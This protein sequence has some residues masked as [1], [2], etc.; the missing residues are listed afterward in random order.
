M[1]GWFFSVRAE[2][3]E[4]PIERQSWGPLAHS[5]CK[6][7]VDVHTHLPTHYGPVPSDEVVV[8]SAMRPG[9]HV[10]LTNSVDDYLAAMGPV[11]VAFVFGIAPRPGEDSVQ[12]L[13]NQGNVNDTA[14]RVAAR[15][16]EKII[17]FMSVHPDEPD[18]IDEIERSAR[19]LGLRGMKLGP[20][21]Q[22]FDPTGENAFRVYSRAQE[23][24]L[25][26]V[27]HQGTSPF[28]DAPLRYAHPL[29][30]DEIAMTF[31]D[32]KVVMAHMAHPW[33]V[34]CVNIIRKHPNVYAD[35]SGA[36]IRPWQAY[37]AFM[38]AHEWGML[39]KLLFAS[40]FPVTAPSETISFL[41]GL[42]GYARKHHLP[43]LP[44]DGLE[45]IIERDTLELLGLR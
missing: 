4:A 26:I 32:L 17:G 1:S 37:H 28:P 31:P 12:V 36:L 19:D 18:V 5:K 20:N 45:A 33:H 35:I 27:F 24:G 7:I 34:D 13:A 42:N 30:M 6:M 25:P 22:N 11:G 40:D 8:E 23:L 2:L 38:H 15:A 44:D 16:P 41:R 10:R 39:H 29:V 9:S 21:Y 43:E 14:A 3:V